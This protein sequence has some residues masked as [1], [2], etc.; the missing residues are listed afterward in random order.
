MIRS[1]V[2]LPGAVEAE[3]ADLGARKERQADVAQDGPLGRDHLG[4][5]VH[6][7]DV[8]G[9]ESRVSVAANAG[10]RDYIV[11]G[12]RQGRPR[13]DGRA[14]GAV[15]GLPAVAASPSSST[16]AAPSVAVVV[17]E[18][19]ARYGFGDGHPFGPDRLAAFVREFDA[20]GP[21]AA[22]A[23]AR[24]ARRHRRGAAR[25]S[26]RASISSWCASAPR[27]GTGLSRCRRHAG[28]SWRLRG[29]RRRGRRDAECRG[30]H[31]GGRVPA[32]L[33]ADR[34][35]HH[36]AR[37]RAAGFCVFNDC[38]VAIELLQARGTE[39]HRLRRH[40]RAPRRRRVL[41]LRGRPRR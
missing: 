18:R 21:R 7:V 35:L 17:S 30:G 13:A 22:R 19:L 2:D 4:Y 8:L 10:C 23:R 1:S 39:A 9:H 41:C 5:A 16:S 32:R 26:H 28:V 6:R 20:R 12:R 24:A 15:L 25:L 14:A 29:G 37:D 34:G 31:H 11:A 27:S 38:G 40:R 33:R 36:A 3:H